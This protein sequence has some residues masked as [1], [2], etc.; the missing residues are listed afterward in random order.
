MR[1]MF[2]RNH[3]KPVFD[4]HISQMDSILKIY[5]ALVSDKRKERFEV[6]LEPFQAMTQLAMLSFCPEGSKLSISN[7]LLYVQIPSWK[8]AIQRAY[9][10][11]QRDDLFYLFKM[12]SRYNKFYGH[13]QNE[14]GYKGK[15]YSTLAELGKKGIDR[16]IQTYSSAQGGTLIHTLQMYRA[17]LDNPE[18]LKSASQP[19]QAETEA[20]ANMDEV[21]IKIRE[22]YD[23]SHFKAVHNVLTL[24]ANDVKNYEAYLHSLNFL[25]QPVTGGIRQWIN[26]NLVF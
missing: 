23:E 6:I 24:A 13:M 16:L 7:N 26:D 8:Q 25:L 21:F 20:E 18:L 19:Q 3:I 1:R 4:L 12:I 11:D 17:M 2:S 22:I 15:L 5:Q 10:H 9:N 14:T